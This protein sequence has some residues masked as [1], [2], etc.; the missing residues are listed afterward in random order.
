MHHVMMFVLEV[1][2]KIASIDVEAQV[3]IN[4][5]K[6]SDFVDADGDFRGG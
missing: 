1:G 4:V 3:G 6:V 5:S 2:S